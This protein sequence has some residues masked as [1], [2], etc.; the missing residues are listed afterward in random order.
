MQVLSES[1]ELKNV[2]ISSHGMLPILEI[3]EICDRKDVLLRLLKIVN[4]VC[5]LF[6]SFQT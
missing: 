6:I 2:I 4:L 3:L 1:P 5:E